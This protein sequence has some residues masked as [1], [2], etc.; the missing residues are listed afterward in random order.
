MEAMMAPERTMDIV[1]DSLR[2]LIDYE[3]AVVL[4]YSGDDRLIVRTMKGPLASPRLAGYSISLAERTDLAALLA[5]G[6]PRLFLTDDDYI[7][8][9]A[10]I[11]D[12]PAGHSCLAA[13]LVIDGTAIGLLTLDH[14]SCGVFS[15]QILRFI[16]VIS[17]LIA[18]ALAQSEAS[19][20]LHDRNSRLTAERNRLL[21]HDAEAF[22]DLAGSSQAWLSALDSIKLVAATES[23]VLLLGETGTG[24]EEAA[25]AIHR[26]SPRSA[27]PF[28]AL[29]C[30]AMPASLAESELFGHEKGSF[31]D[32]RSLRRGRF[33]LA[34]SGTLFLDEI[35]DLPLEIQPK[36]LRALQEGTLERVGG[37]TPVRVDVRIIV[38][39]HEDLG[40]AVDA[41]RFREDLF[42]RVAIF[43]LR[44][45][46]LRE[47]HGDAILLA[48]LFA[49]RLRARPGWG[50]L[51]FSEDALRLLETTPWPGNVR[52]LR[53]AVERAAILARGGIISAA[54]LRAGD[55]A[56]GRPAPCIKDAACLEGCA[57]LGAGTL[58]DAE[59]RHITA[60]L[61]R[62]GGRIYGTGGAAQALGLKPST[63]Q[64]RMKKLGVSRTGGAR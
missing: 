33:E 50:S 17:R 38:A 55:W 57:E 58:Q 59:R 41:G 40:T 9:Y 37:E 19:R 25:K 32:A 61:E 6:K 11:L 5:T 60:A 16:G 36:L 39:T 54:E 28:V 21:K 48:E 23:P 26:L 20:A 31:T 51:S 46:P 56:K 43:P 14:R 3:L 13:P 35:G 7:D 15:E 63:L 64:S 8:T 24:K 62:S 45:P 10:D 12:L 22:R 29:N 34:D 44:M 53:N 2:E 30:S 49:S 47:R 18:V 4:G 27:G 1:L 52:E 42:Y